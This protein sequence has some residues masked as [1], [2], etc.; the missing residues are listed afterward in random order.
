LELKKSGARNVVGILDASETE[1]GVWM[2]LEFEGGKTDQL[3]WFVN[4]LRVRT[5]FPREVFDLVV[6]PVVVGLCESPEPGDMADPVLV[7]RLAVAARALELRRGLVLPRGLPPELV[8]G[9]AH[10]W[11][12]TV[13]MAALADAFVN[14]GDA[15]QSAAT[16]WTRLEQV[17]PAAAMAWLREDPDVTEALRAFLSSDGDRVGTLAGIIRRAETDVFGAVRVP[18]TAED[19]AADV[20]EPGV[21]AGV[22]AVPAPVEGAAASPIAQAF[23]VWL[24]EAARRRAIEVNAPTAVI[25]HLEEGT[26]V[27]DPLAFREFARRVATGECPQ[28]SGTTAVGWDLAKEVRR[29]VM[30]AGWH[31]ASGHEDGLVDGCLDSGGTVRGLL[32]RPSIKVLRRGGTV[33]GAVCT[34]VAKV[35]A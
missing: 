35:G 7:R 21:A 13:V 8:G 17:A 16:R 33:A 1:S 9:L 12:W 15:A 22:A 24:R 28:P 34:S 4:L 27:A 30:R 26:L 3:A 31:V 5:G 10:R 25:C 23:L 32:L 18:R 14:E 19:L 20:G 11:T 29:E 2:A 6:L